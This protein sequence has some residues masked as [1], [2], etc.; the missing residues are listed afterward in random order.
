MRANVDRACKCDAFSSGSVA[1]AAR[2]RLAL[3]SLS[4]PLMH[5][6]LWQPMPIMIWIA[7]VVEAAIQNWAGARH[8][9]D[10]SFLTHSAC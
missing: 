7:I 4:A 1:A 10:L 3:L 9:L 2:A 5:A 6:Q 8:V